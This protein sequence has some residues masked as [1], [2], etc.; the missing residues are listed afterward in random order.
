MLADG[1]TSTSSL[2]SETPIG[3]Y[4]LECERME[5]NYKNGESVDI[6]K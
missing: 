2:F 4:N 3:Y 6:Y 5:L 1:F